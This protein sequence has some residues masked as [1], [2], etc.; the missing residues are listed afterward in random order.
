MKKKPSMTNSENN[1]QSKTIHKCPLCK[2]DGVIPSIDKDGHERYKVCSCVFKESIE[3]NSGRPEEF[4]DARFHN[5]STDIYT[6]QKDQQLAIDAKKLM[7]IY[8][9]QF[10][11]IQQDQKGKGLYF[12]SP[13]PGSGKSRAA[14]TLAYE[15][16]EAGK[17]KFFKFLTFPA[18]LEKIK[19]GWNKANPK[20]SEMIVKEFIHDKEFLIIDDIGTGQLSPKEMQYAWEI[21]NGR[22][23]NNKITIFT[24]NYPIDKLPMLNFIEVVE[25]RKLQDRIKKMVLEVRFPNEKIRAKISEKENMDLLEQLFNDI[26]GEKD[27]KIY[28]PKDDPYQLK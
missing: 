9:N 24:A 1:E 10:E 19:E 21:I 26:S 17:I 27:K 16:F 22:M 11:K 15:L 25:R 6:N 20:S 5:F 2:D 28:G 13:E 4:K 12:F 14:V 8:V 18:L 23:A 3:T 7:Q